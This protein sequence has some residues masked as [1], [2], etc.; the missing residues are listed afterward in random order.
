MKVVAFNGSARRD[1]NTALLIAH[2]FA[3]LE[4]ACRRQA[5]EVRS[6]DAV[7]IR[8]GW[9]VHWKDPETFVGHHHGV[10]GPDES[11]AAWLAERRIRITGS[12]TIAY[13]CI[14]PE[15]GHALLPVHR[16]M[17]VEHGIHIIE[18]L[19]L[20]ELARDGVNEFLFVVTPLKV[21]GATGIPV[22]PVALVS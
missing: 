22:R 4:A 3:E 16:T 19:N 10:P 1:G 5:V 13:E 8:S 15:R 9:P 14:Y 17:L 7:L 6:G 21:V 20:T 11:A 2:V 12:E 18:V